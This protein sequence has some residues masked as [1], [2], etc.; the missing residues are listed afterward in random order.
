VEPYSSANPLPEVFCLLE[1]LS[2][3]ELSLHLIVLISL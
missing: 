1:F 3:S 2:C